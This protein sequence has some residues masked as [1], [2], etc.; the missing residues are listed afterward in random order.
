MSKVLTELR[1]LHGEANE[2]LDWDVSWETKYH[3]IFSE[4]ISGRVSELIELDYYDPDTS[5]EED[6][7]A[8]MDAFNRAMGASQ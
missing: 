3:I 2:I 6:V 7:R 8:F 5:Y 4:H 1:D